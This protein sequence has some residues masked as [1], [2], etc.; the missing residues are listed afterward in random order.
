M[1]ALLF[2]T[3]VT[4]CFVFTLPESSQSFALID[5]FEKQNL[6]LAQSRGRGDDYEPKQKAPSI[7]G[8]SNK[9][10]SAKSLGSSGKAKAR[11]VLHKRSM[12]QHFA[13]IDSNGDKQLGYKEM[14]HYFSEMH[15]VF[16]QNGDGLVSRREAPA[17]MMRYTLS[18]KGFPSG[19]LSK[20]EIARRFKRLFKV[21]DKNKDGRMSMLEM[22]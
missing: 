19:G 3:F 15:T 5:V 4:G 6:V 1:H 11:K 9:G 14:V 22:L 10:K 2:A 8:S 12:W 13:A 21:V 7:L 17:I 18:G 16:D 20:A